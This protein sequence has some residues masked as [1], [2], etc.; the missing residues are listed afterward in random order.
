MLDHSYTKTKIHMRKLTLLLIAVALFA[1]QA[2]AQRTVTGKVTDEKGLPLANVSVLVRG[3]TVGTI[4]KND[5]TY[6][7]TVPANARALVFSA[8]DMSPVEMAIGTGNE[9]NATL[10]AEDKTIAEVVVTALGIKKDK[11]T[12]GY[13]VTQLTAQ[14]LT[15]AHT[16]NITNALAGKIPGVRVSGSGGSF[17]GSSIIIR[18]FTTF[19]GSN[20]PLFV[21]DGVPI[22]NGGGGIALQTGVTRSNRA[23]DLNQEDIESI[24]VLKGPSASVLYGSRASNGVI[25]ITTKKGKAGTRN[26]ITY[27][28]YYQMETVNRFPDY[29]N[30]YA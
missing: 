9:V 27:S 8:V 14:E 13:G 25:L 2:I 30:E 12:L 11:K 24:T 20:Q 15:Q 26:A 7:L 10:K 29:Q 23:I 4:T 28:T 18:G 1:F 17:A 22:D 3:T 16:T 5:G 6:A 21:V 19:T